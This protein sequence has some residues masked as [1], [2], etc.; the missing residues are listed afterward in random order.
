MFLALKCS[1]D[2]M[3]SFDSFECIEIIVLKSNFYNR[4]ILVLTQILIKYPITITEP[5]LNE[6]DPYSPLRRDFTRST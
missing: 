3:A 4:D 5:S 6:N 2:L 1:K